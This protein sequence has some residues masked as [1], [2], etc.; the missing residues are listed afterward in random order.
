MTHVRPAS[1]GKAGLTD[2]ETPLA[3]LFLL[4]SLIYLVVLV[5][6]PLIAVV[7]FAFSDV[8][9]RGIH[10]IGLGDFRAIFADGVF[11][12]SLINTLIVT[13]TTVV[14]SMALGKILANLLT[15]RFRSNTEPNQ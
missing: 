13:G 6:V 14:A 11:W 3:W 15:A 12:R 9:G 1:E 4:P 10:F 2:R 8:S 7:A 5:L